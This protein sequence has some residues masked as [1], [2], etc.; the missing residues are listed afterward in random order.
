M[1]KPAPSLAN[2]LDGQSFIDVADL[3]ASE[4][5][6]VGHLATSLHAL[7]SH[8]LPT[9]AAVSLTVSAVEHIALS[10]HLLE[11]I[12]LE[13]SVLDPNDAR[14]TTRCSESITQHIQN[15]V[16]PEQIAKEF[17][18]IYS[19]HLEH[20]YLAIRPSFITA[21]VHHNQM[22]AL[23]VKG[24]ANAIE[25]LF[26]VWSRLYAPKHLAERLEEWKKGHKQPAT[27]VFQVMVNAESSGVG[28]FTP[29]TAKNSATITI[30]S[31]WGVTPDHDTVFKQ[32]DW[33]EVDA[34][35]WEIK[36]R[37]IGIKR[38]EWVRR[39]DHLHQQTVQHRLQSHPSLTTQGAVALAKMVQVAHKGHFGSYLME[40][41]ASRDAAFI[42]DVRTFEHQ[43]Q[44]SGSV[45]FLPTAEQL[46]SALP[47]TSSPRTYTGP[48]ATKV[49]VTFSRPDDA[50]TQLSGAD[51]VGLL[52]SE[53]AYAQLP[54]HPFSLV[55]RGKADFI[56]KELTKLI[57]SAGQ[58]HSS[59][60][61]L[62]F[63]SQNFT[64]Q[65]LQQFS[66]GDEY[67]PFEQNPYIGYRGAVRIIHDYTL[68]DVELDALQ[69]AH[70]E[71]V[72]HL[73]LMIPF[74]RSHSELAI[75]SH[76][77]AKPQFSTQ[78]FLQLWMQAN[79]PENLLNIEQYC[80]PSLAGISLNI[81]SIHALLQ[82]VDPDN[83]DVFQ[84]YPIHHQGMYQHLKEA[85]HK[86]HQHNT[87][88][89]L[90]LEQ[91][92]QTLIEF[93]AE[94]G[95]DAVT[96][97]AKDIHRARQRIIEVEHQRIQS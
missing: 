67:E 82:G 73:G 38:Q 30:F 45:Y 53:W 59:E 2:F 61:P 28:I 90:Q 69:D 81:Q 11:L 25:S 66:H 6:E 70:L 9:P 95:Y 76:H 32:G 77:F 13:F 62:L 24:E 50:K 7:H 55:R 18:K 46:K 47:N 23:H 35:T 10:N 54:E 96:V 80:M 27:F 14:Q 71:G 34:K 79:T 65:E 63:R 19:Q 31:Q 91:F 72:Q 52:R 26:E 3:T 15:M 36:Q 48:T 78:R 43:P 29:A 87:K 89:I 33:F 17:Q 75:I 5:K 74:V 12:E 44:Q 22:S 42:L 21:S 56:R 39:L 49:F 86:T 20:T 94:L 97:R 57:L 85:R 41:A 37:H 88:L 60:F 4:Y 16:L 40:W 58:H 83:S 51:G 84:L 68:F 92:D 8:G 64:S 93:A 1:V